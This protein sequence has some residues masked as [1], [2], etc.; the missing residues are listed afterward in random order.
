MKKSFFLWLI[1]ILVLVV[2]ACTAPNGTTVIPGMPD[3]T[4]Y[5][6]YEN[7]ES[8]VAGNFAQTTEKIESINVNWLTGSV[9][10]KADEKAET[11]V[12]REDYQPKKGYEP[13]SIH[14]YLTDTGTL[15]V[16]FMRVNLIVST[17]IPVKNLVITVPKTAAFEKIKITTG[18]AKTVVSDLTCRDFAQ[19]SGGIGG[20][21]YAT[22]CTFGAFLSNITAGDTVIENCT[23]SEKTEFIMGTGSVILS[24]SETALLKGQCRT[25]DLILTSCRVD[26]ADVDVS[27]T[28]DCYFTDLTFTDFTA[29]CVSGDILVHLSPD[30]DGC[31]LNCRSPYT[32]VYPDPKP[33]ENEKNTLRLRSTSGKI[34]F[35]DR[36]EIE[37]K[38]GKDKIEEEKEAQ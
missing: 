27:L 12:V 32:V 8:Y 37:A 3:T 36:E 30:L 19:D 13:Y 18:T 31:V 23:F 15:F 35:L 26:K 11:I 2:S 28:G 29:E 16:K 25:G 7:G 9:T 4:R 6:S 33:V 20:E 14:T 10:L 38:I 22:N 5:Y 24:D 17:S 1:F 34:K 21:L